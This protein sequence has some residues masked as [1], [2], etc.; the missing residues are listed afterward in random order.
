MNM[1]IIGS[2]G[3]RASLVLGYTV[4]SERV[5]EHISGRKRAC[6]KANMQGAV[7]ISAD[8]VTLG[9]SYRSWGAVCCGNQNNNPCMQCLQ[10]LLQPPSDT[11]N[12]K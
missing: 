11:V 9:P 12:G 4:I 6:S 3:S 7:T 10:M 1:M 2:Q 5:R 8:E